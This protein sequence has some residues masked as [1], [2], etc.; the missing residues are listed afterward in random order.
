MSNQ[1][2]P[3]DLNNQQN[4]KT[5]DEIFEDPNFWNLDST[6][7]TPDT[8]STNPENTHH[9]QLTDPHAPQDPTQSEPNTKSKPITIEPIQRKSELNNNTFQKNVATEPQ[10]EAATPKNVYKTSLAPIA[11]TA[12][13]TTQTKTPTDIS[14]QENEQTPPARTKDPKSIIEKIASIIC[15][16]A[17]IGVL[18]Y[19]VH[20]ASKQHNFDTSKQHDDNTPATGTHATIESIETWWTEPADDNT[21]FGVLLVPSATITLGPESKSGAVRCVFYSYEKGLQDNLRPKGDPFLLAFSNGKFTKTGTNKIT[22]SGTSGFKKLAHFQYYTQQD[23][24]R[25][26][27]QISEAGSSNTKKDKFTPLANAPIDPISK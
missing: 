16:I 24:N 17:I 27:I 25:W 15:Y 13:A 7:L 9:D 19:L 12:P 20:Y 22:I 4:P 21:Q 26:T 23:E 5:N 2:D 14:I 18:S 8:N 3:N 1:P 6:P 10:E 11:A